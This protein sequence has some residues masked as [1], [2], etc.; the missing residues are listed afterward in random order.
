MS[1][2]KAGDLVMVVKR[3]R[4]GCPSDVTGMVFRVRSVVVNSGYYCN[5]CGA[6]EETV[7]VF[8]D[9]FDGAALPMWRLIEIDPPPIAEDAPAVEELTA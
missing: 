7:I 9:G 1:E 5:Q 2:I 4:C 8:V 3:R 6:V